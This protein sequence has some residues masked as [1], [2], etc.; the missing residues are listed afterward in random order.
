[1]PLSF[2]I[3]IDEKMDRSCKNIFFVSRY[4][5]INYKLIVPNLFGPIIY[6]GIAIIHYYMIK[7]LYILYLLD[8]LK[9]HFELLASSISYWPAI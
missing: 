7:P 4:K 2:P 8:D 5:K 3:S 1:M 9:L 6:V